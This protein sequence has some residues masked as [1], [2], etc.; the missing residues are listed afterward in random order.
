[1]LRVGCKHAWGSVWM[2]E[3]DSQIDDSREAGHG[4]E[5]NTQR[6]DNPLGQRILSY[7]SADRGEQLSY[8]FRYIELLALAHAE[9]RTQSRVGKCESDQLCQTEVNRTYKFFSS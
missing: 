2:R 4:Q 1:M 8:L 3:Q 7:R 6:Q 9:H 5:G